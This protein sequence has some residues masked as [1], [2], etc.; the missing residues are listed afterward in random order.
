MIYNAGQLPGEPLHRGHDVEDE[1]RLSLRDAGVRHPRHRVRRRDEEGR[2]HDHE[3]PDAEARRAVDALLGHGGRADGGDR[4]SCSACPAPARRRCRPIRSGCLIG[5]DEHCWSDDGIFNIEGGCYAKAIDLS[6]EAEPDIF[7]ALRFGAVLENVV[8][9]PKTHIVDFRRHAASP[10]TRA[11]LS[12][13]STSTNAKIPC[14]GRPPDGRHLSHLRRVRRAAA[15]Q[16]AD[17]RA[18]DVSLHQRLHGESRRHRG[19]A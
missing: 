7:Q 14:V 4:R 1:R 17:A 12:R 15:G 19:R 11:A 2:L 16:P 8:Y 9:D 3:L 13:S 6:A 5:D 10:R 18:G